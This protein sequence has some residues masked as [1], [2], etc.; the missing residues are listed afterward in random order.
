[1]HGGGID[2]R[3][4]SF[5]GSGPYVEL[6]R[7]PDFSWSAT[8]SGTD[9]IDQ[10]VEDALRRQRHEVPVPRRLPRHD[11]L[12]MPARLSPGA[13]PPAG[14]V[15]F[16]E[17]VHGPVIGYATVDGDAGGGLVQALHARTRDGQ[18]ARL[19]GL[20]HDTSIRPS[21]FIDAASKIELS[22]N[23]FYAR[24]GQHRVVLERP[25][26]DSR[27]RREPRPA[28]RTAPASY[29]WRGFVK[30]K[31]HPQVINPSSG[32]IV[33]WNNK[34]ADGWTAADNEWS[35][36]SVHRV[37]LLNN[38]IAREPTQ[39]TLGELTNAMNYAATQDLRNVDG[40]AGDQAGARHRAARR[41]RA[42]RQMLD[43]LEQWR[44]AGLQPARHA[45]SDGKID[46][47][48]RGDHGPGVE[49]D[50]RRGHGPGARVRSSVSW[51]R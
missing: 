51:P 7:G 26:A 38:A 4:A 43:L 40:A 12:Q 42:S 24:Q 49:Q 31:D 34:P 2:A 14:P 27:R 30:A 28:D 45:T 9:I 25:R 35:Y 41:A 21:S 18:L 15:N 3:G 22:F 29:E 47:P 16:K 36:G 20:Q 5:P 48:R 37:D 11:G 19:R 32:Q 39:M 44:A 17:T 10:F 13:G 33:N 1:M 23:W 6:G 8:S 46:A 50:R